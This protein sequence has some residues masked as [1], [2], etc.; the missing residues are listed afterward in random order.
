MEIH[1]EDDDFF[2]LDEA[3]VTGQFAGPGGDEKGASPQLVYAHSIHF[4]K[5]GLPSLNPRLQLF[6]NIAKFFQWPPPRDAGPSLHYYAPDRALNEKL[7]LCDASIGDVPVD[8]VPI[9]LLNTFHPPCFLSTHVM[10]RG[11]PAMA[12]KLKLLGF[13]RSGEIRAAESCNMAP[14]FVWAFL[15]VIYDADR[16]VASEAALVQQLRRVLS[17]MINEGLRSVAIPVADFFGLHFPLLPGM[18]VLCRA[19]RRFLERF[20]RELERVA[21][22]FSSPLERA[23]CEKLLVRYFPRADVPLPRG[24][25]DAPG[26]RAELPAACFVEKGDFDE[27]GAP[28][29][30][31]PRTS[32]FRLVK[33]PGLPP[34]VAFTPH[35]N[36][37]H[38]IQRRVG[39]APPAL[40][41][42]IDAMMYDSSV[43][44]NALLEASRTQDLSDIAD[45]GCVVEAEPQG[46]SF[47][48]F[49]LV[50]DRL[51]AKERGLSRLVMYLLRLAP[52][53]GFRSKI[54]LIVVLSATSS[55]RPPA[56]WLQKIFK[57]VGMYY[58]GRLQRICVVGGSVSQTAWLRS[59][60][61]SKMPLAQLNTLLEFFKSGAELDAKYDLRQLGF[62][63]G[64]VASLPAD[65][66]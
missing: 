14:R 9:P 38:K 46:L 8:V 49:A 50:V 19:L 63:R 59:V 53:A 35:A 66:K 43:N 26:A 24:L 54:A 55:L 25:C 36:D 56:P 44:F 47:R 6:E 30:A 41:T 34:S 40:S 62:T 28:V 11:G 39:C 10:L 18:T 52:W 4:K 37:I 23:L 64:F 58:P 51:P 29:L 32:G 2:H 1:I 17:R 45:S 21:L 12:E 16:P 31:R 20:P 57:L 27:W 15:P 22:V 42:Q 7:V 13:L 60:F 33:T 61:R 3:T 48:I 65:V 5:N